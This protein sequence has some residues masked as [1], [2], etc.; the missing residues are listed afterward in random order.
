MWTQVVNSRLWAKEILD[1]V[2]PFRFFFHTNSC[3]QKA[4]YWKNRELW[5]HEMYFQWGLQ[6]HKCK[7]C[8]KFTLLATTS[9]PYWISSSAKRAT[10]PPWLLLSSLEDQPNIAVS[11]GTE[12]KKESKLK[13]KIKKKIPILLPPLPELRN[14]CWYSYLYS[15]WTK[16]N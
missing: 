7:P 14:S 5:V 12:L 1:S 13:I 2:F 9:S 11:W 6:I 16:R 8:Y 4:T 3:S 10:H 15:C